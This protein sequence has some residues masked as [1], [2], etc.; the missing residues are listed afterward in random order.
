MKGVASFTAVLQQ[1]AISDGYAGQIGCCHLGLLCQLYHSTST[2]E[3][4]YFWVEPISSILM[5]VLWC[6][7]SSFRFQ[8]GHSEHQM[9]AQPFCF[10][11]LQS[12]KS[13]PMGGIYTSWWQFVAM[14]WVH[15]VAM[16]P[17]ALR[18]EK[19]DA[20]CYSSSSPLSHSYSFGDSSGSPNS[21]CFPTWW[22]D[23]WTS[24]WWIYSHLFG[25]MFYCS[26]TNLPRVHRQSVNF[27]LLPTWTED[28]RF[29]TGLAIGS[30]CIWEVSFSL[31]LSVPLA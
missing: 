18:S 30:L 25:R 31:S 5:S 12:F 16:P 11:P 4:L 15:T 27:S 6:L 20:S 13:I 9:W 1:K 26:F 19:G 24:V 10:A 3:L 22:V 17:S 29:L 21:C 7:L 23:D 8:C 2:Y 28:Y 14:S